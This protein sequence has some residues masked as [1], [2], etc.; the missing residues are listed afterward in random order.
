MLTSES[1]LPLTTIEI[2][3][4]PPLELFIA[5]KAF[6]P[7][8]TTV[9][10]ARAVR[11]QP[12]DVVFDLGTGIGP[13]AIKAA[14]DGA[15]LVYGVD[16][17]TLHCELARMNV[18]KYGLQD[19]VTIHQGNF[20][21]PFELEPALTG[22]LADVMI[23]DV[24]GIADPVARALGWYSDQVP[25]GGADG[26]EVII[27]LLRRAPEFLSL[28]GV[29]Y[30]PIAVD[31]SDSAKVLDAAREV[32][33]DVTNAMDKPTIQFPL[34]DAELQ[35]IDNAYGGHRPSYI[36]IQPGRRPF[37]RGQIW[38]ASNPI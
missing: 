13:L 31:L 8:P 5:E 3:T 9:R 18:V 20:F 15:R 24:S 29:L 16:P 27:D 30:F 10:F 28:R 14:L 17:V 2:R 7:N 37:W 12:G 25:A 21:E 33:A 11:I 32:F 38:K 35:A 34:S 22:T 23:G 36:N 1:Q 6:R 4:D 26:T 19:K